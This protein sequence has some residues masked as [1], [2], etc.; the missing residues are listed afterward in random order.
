MHFK[1]FS[2]L[3][4]YFFVLFLNIHEIH[5]IQNSLRKFMIF[6]KTILLLNIL[7]IIH[8]RIS[9]MIGFFWLLVPT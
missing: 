3:K 6:E 5:E 2:L 9:N 1:I 4:R 7:K 8:F